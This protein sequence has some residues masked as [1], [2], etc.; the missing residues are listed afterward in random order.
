MR[1]GMC[2]NLADLSA[3]KAAGY[4]F[5]E[6]ATAPALKVGSPE[7]EW[8]A[9]REAVRSAPLP[10]L[11]C[12]LLFAGDLRLV[13]PERNLERTLDYVDLAFARLAEI[14]GTVQ[15][16]GSGGARRV[17]EGYPAEQAMDELVEL[18]VAMGPLAD[19]HGLVVAMEHLRPA[20]CNLLTTV[21]ETAAFVRRVNHPAIR[22]LVDGYHLAQAG[23]PYE[24]IRACGDLLVH[25]HLADPAT[26]AEPSY[27]GSDLRP[28]FR[29]LKAVG[30]DGT[31]SIECAW[32]DMPNT[33]QATH[34][35]V[36]AQWA[37][38]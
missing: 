5:V 21:A 34:D 12:N 33:L 10:T 38:S 9:T 8:A 24:V 30:Y 20:E 27:A 37:E 13:G 23:E 35:L 6:R 3:V 36:V 32:K 16:F 25:V 17:P 11:T 22:L 28:L 14:G 7:D 29:E 31:L 26:R 19:R 2:T 15:V 4:E 18:A 1:L